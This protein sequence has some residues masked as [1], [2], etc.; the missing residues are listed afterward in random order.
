[1][2]QSS[3][4]GM[5]QHDLVYSPIRYDSLP[6]EDFVLRKSDGLPTYHFANVVDDWEMGVTH[7]LRGE[8]WLPSTPKHLALYCALELQPPQFGH[9]PLLINADGSKLS[10]RAGDVRVEDYIVRTLGCRGAQAQLLNIACE[11]TGQRLRARS[12]PQLRRAARLVTTG[13][14]VRTPRRKSRGQR[15]AEH[16]RNE[17]TSV[18]ARCTPPITKLTRLARSF[19]LKAS[20]KIGLLCP[21]PSSTR[22]IA[23]ICSASWLLTRHRIFEPSWKDARPLSCE[24]R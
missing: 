1:M 11:S 24:K 21:G 7:V 16:E 18:H 15:C 13:C 5:T 14:D 2:S 19:R 12:S 17:R 9:L 6:V 3:A 4:D 22:S 8:E 23:R 20:T 10:K